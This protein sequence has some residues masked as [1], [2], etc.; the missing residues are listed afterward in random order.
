MQRGRRLTGLAQRLPA[1]L[2]SSGM[3]RIVGT[4]VG[5]GQPEQDGAKLLQLADRDEE[6]PST[7]KPDEEED[8]AMP[9][10]VD[11]GLASVITQV[12]SRDQQAAPLAAAAAVQ[13]AG[14]PGEE[15]AEVRS[16]WKNKFRC[17]RGG[18]V[19]LSLCTGGEHG[20]SMPC[21]S[22]L[23]P[24]PPP[25]RPP[26]GALPQEHLLLPGSRPERAVC[27]AG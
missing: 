17:A 12:S 16:T 6:T 25:N 9:D 4:L 22:L 14:P 15:G 19:V 20:M 8:G 5:G 10:A 26:L 18:R 21:C 7:S 23:R 24:R 1:L 27:A 11:E 2:S 13:Y 3:Q